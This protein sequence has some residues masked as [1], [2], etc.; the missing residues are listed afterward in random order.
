MQSERLFAAI[1]GLGG[2]ARLVLLPNEGHFYRAKESILHALAE[3]DA[4]LERYVRGAPAP[5]APSADTGGMT[6][7]STQP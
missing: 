5:P 2:I 7:S 1:K 4:W 3:Q 6:G